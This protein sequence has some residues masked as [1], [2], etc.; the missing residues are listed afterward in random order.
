MLYDSV[1]HLIK[2]EYI[3]REE[4]IKCR[5]LPFSRP[6]DFPAPHPGRIQRIGSTQTISFRWRAGLRNPVIKQESDTGDRCP[7]QIES[8]AFN[9]RC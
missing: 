2:L 5:R 6:R 9:A 7:P 1:C 4:Q 3:P 8:S